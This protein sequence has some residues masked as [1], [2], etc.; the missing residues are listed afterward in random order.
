[1]WSEKNLAKV[2][3]V[4]TWIAGSVSFVS[5]LLFLIGIGGPWGLFFVGLVCSALSIWY[6]RASIHKAAEEEYLVLEVVGKYWKTMGPGGLFWV[7]YF[8]TKIRGR[9]D[10]LAH[11]YPLFEEPDVM[12]D[13]KEGSAKPKGGR[14]FVKLSKCDVDAPKKAVYS[15]S[16]GDGEKSGLP[17]AVVALVENACRS[18]FNSLTLQQGLEEGQAGFDIM[19]KLKN[20]TDPRVKKHSALL[21]KSLKEWGLELCPI[22]VVF[23]DFDLSATVIQSRERRHK[24]EQEAFAAVDEARGRAQEI[25]G[26]MIAAISEATGEEREEVQKKILADPVLMGRMI[27][28]AEEMVRMKTGVDG[29]AWTEIRVNGASGF[30]QVLLSLITAFKTVGAPGGGG[31]KP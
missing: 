1:M 27:S 5:L 9:P 12:I 17:K 22:S 23:A 2:Y 31:G 25:I 21:V 16:N 24:A 30:E 11:E 4:E 28:F 20:H 19:L 7:P 10:Y 15:V 6:I 8:S 29:N 26:V 3:W 18:Y 14:V 13:F